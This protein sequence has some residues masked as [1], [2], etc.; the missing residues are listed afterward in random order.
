MRVKIWYNF[1][2]F[3]PKTLL[4]VDNFVSKIRKFFA[5]VI[6]SSKWITFRSSACSNSVAFTVLMSV[7]K[8]QYN[9]RK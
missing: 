8:I 1:E 7:P 5:R 2:E 6:L 9:D 4:F 3:N